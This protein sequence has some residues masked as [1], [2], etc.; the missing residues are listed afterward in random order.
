MFLEIK[1]R[2]TL[3]C[4]PSRFHID[5]TDL[6]I[7]M[8]NQ[9][10]LNTKEKFWQRLPSDALSTF[11]FFFFPRFNFT[12]QIYIERAVNTCLSAAL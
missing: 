1:F 7:E 2:L 6:Q 9:E 10:T 3:I 11:F 5:C 4:L 8:K 12:R